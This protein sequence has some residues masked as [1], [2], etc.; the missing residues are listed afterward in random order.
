MQL[1]LNVSDEVFE[2]TLE[3]QLFAVK[4]EDLQEALSG[5]IKEYFTKEQNLEKILFSRD[6]YG[7]YG[8][9]PTEIFKRVLESLDYSGLQVVADDCIKLLTERYESFL[10]GVFTQ[11]LVDQLTTSYSFQQALQMAISSELYRQQPN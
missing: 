10:R 3:K 8:H 7:S 11:M 2:S 9:H 6:G 1:V 4:P 5:A